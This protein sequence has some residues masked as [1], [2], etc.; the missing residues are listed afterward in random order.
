MSDEERES[1]S[2]DRPRR[3]AARVAPGAPIL[4]GDDVGTSRAGI[5]AV[6]DIG[7]KPHLVTCGHVF[8]DAGRNVFARA[9]DG[10]WSDSE[11]I[12]VL[13]SSYLDRSF[14]DG[15]RPIDAAVCA[16]TEHGIAVLSG[17]L[18]ARTWFQSCRAPSRALD[19]QSVVF[20]PTNDD[21]GEPIDM[22]VTS[23]CASSEVLFG[24]FPADG[25][26]ELTHEVIPGDSGSMLA[27]Q[28]GDTH[29][30]I[31]LCSGQLAQSV[32]LFTPLA[33]VLD[34][35]R[36]DHGEVELWNPAN[37]LPR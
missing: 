24:G 10:S 9:E 5:A 17:S 35:L 31:G 29:E 28:H 25:F 6:V 13:L 12:A 15:A 3:V 32:S 20:W 36:A 8:N 26:I 2:G 34:R 22:L 1:S 19:R 23:H 27:V 18:E 4:V 16:L 14:L 11:P 37:E 7:G 33:T 21:F 30:M